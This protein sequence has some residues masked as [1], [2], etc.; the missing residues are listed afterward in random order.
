MKDSLMYRGEAI[1]E[2]AA[3]IQERPRTYAEAL[4]AKIENYIAKL[5]DFEVRCSMPDVDKDALLNEITVLTDSMLQTCAQ[6]EQEVNDP[7]PIK[8]AQV[9][10]REK[11]HPVLSKSYFVNRA[12]TWPQGHQGDFMMLEQIYKNFPMSEGLGSYLD[13]YVLSTPLSVGVQ[14]RIV[15]MRDLLKEE[16]IRR[17][18]PKVLDVACGSCREVFELSPEIK[19]SGAKF[20]CVDLDPAALEFALDRFAYA[21]LGEEHAELIQYNALRMFD[22]ETAQTE[23]GMQDVIYSIGFFDYLPDDFLV[24]LLR[25]FYLML[26]PGGKLIASFKDAERYP[27]QHC[28]WFVDWDGF[29]QRTEKD[30]LKVLQDA[31][32]P[33]NAISMSRV[34]SRSIVFYSIT[35]Q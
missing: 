33:S 3:L 34:A 31:N 24:K 2:H 9:Y 29:L 20:T 16:L 21:G 8:Q 22:L 5:N 25:S 26:N 19:A 27:S 7:L 17:T 30:F 23:F 1:Q 15:K 35:K 28:H 32:I 6:F 18:N 11:T 12:R 4:D 14:E 13:R 10:F